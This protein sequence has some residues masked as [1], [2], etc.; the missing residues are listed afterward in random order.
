MNFTMR[1]ATLMLERTPQT[2]QHTLGGLS[3]EWLN[4][5]EGENTW[6]PLQV[7]EHLIE[8]ERTNWIPR[9]EH[10]LL[11]GE[12]EPFPPFDRFAHLNNQAETSLEEKLQ[13]FKTI[14]LQNIARLTELI[15]PDQH[16]E[17]TGLHPAFGPVKVRELI[18]TW[19]VH[20]LTHI[21]QIVRAMAKRYTTDVGPWKEYLGILQ[22][23]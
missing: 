18:S 7:L 15:D 6:N 19:V 10:L 5:T 9:L 4:C 23:K 11:A 22:D 13:D 21:A 3:S 12:S 8:A 16:L 2:L 1:E 17:L 20:D 14:R